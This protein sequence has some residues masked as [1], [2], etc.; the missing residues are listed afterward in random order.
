M[1]GGG[2]EREHVFAP[3][4][5]VINAS[6]SILVVVAATSALSALSNPLMAPRE[7]HKRSTIYE[8]YDL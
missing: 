6:P 2:E 3:L 5:A 7:K 8:P 1:R 4:E